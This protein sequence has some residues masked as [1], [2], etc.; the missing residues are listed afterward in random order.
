V[1]GCGRAWP[2]AADQPERTGCQRRLALR[3][4]RRWRGRY[5]LGADGVG[6]A[7]PGAWQP[8]HFLALRARRRR[9]G[10]YAPE[11]PHVLPRLRTLSSGDGGDFDD[12]VRCA[13]LRER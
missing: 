12:V 9:R 8:G 4:R 1:Q 10:R 11:R 13:L 5:T 6:A 7:R 2:W 3:A